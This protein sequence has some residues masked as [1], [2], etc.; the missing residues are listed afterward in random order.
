MKL[1]ASR[2]KAHIM[3]LQL[4]TRRERLGDLLDHADIREF[5]RG[6]S[7]AQRGSYTFP[8][9]DG[10]PLLAACAAPIWSIRLEGDDWAPEAAIDQT[11][12][13][14]PPHSVHREVWTGH[15]I[16]NPHNRWPREAAHVVGRMREWLMS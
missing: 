10:E 11:L 8:T 15:Q 2:M 14:L 12:N 16:S 9:F 3:G 6:A 4:S 5:T 7:M 13:K 1:Q